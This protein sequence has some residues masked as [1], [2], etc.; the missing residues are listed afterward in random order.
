MRTPCKYNKCFNQSDPRWRVR[1]RHCFN[2]SLLSFTVHRYIFHPFPSLHHPLIKSLFAVHTIVAKNLCTSELLPAIARSNFHPC[3]LFRIA[4]VSA[5]TSH[6]FT[7][8]IA[9]TKAIAKSNG[10]SSS[11]FVLSV[12]GHILITGL[13]RL[14][15][16]L[17]CQTVSSTLTGLSMSY[18]L[19]VPFRLNAHALHNVR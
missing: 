5:I 11:V 13:F 15:C 17:S 10:V 1:H 7:A 2:P 6:T 18:F 4:Y 12:I 3:D 16:V 19:S 9:N 8:M 14:C